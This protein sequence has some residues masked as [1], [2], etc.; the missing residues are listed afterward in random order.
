MENKQSYESSRMKQVTLRGT[1]ITTS[2][3]GFGCAGLMRLPTEAERQRV[4]ATAFD[5]GVRHFD[6]ARMYGLGKVEG[7]LGDFTRTRR[8]QLTITTKFGIQLNAYASR[9]SNIQSAVRRILALSPALR[10]F[11]RR[12]SQALYKEQAFGIEDARQSLETSLRELKTDYIDV[13]LLHECS[14]EGLRGDDLLG[15]LE[16]AHSSGK[17]RCYGIATTFP[18]TLDICREFPNYAPVVQ[19]D[20]DAL[21]RHL[22]VL[23][24]A[25]TRGI[26]THS[27]LSQSL[28]AV[29]QSVSSDTR[30]AAR[31]SEATGLDCSSRAIL[32]SLLLAYCLR[33]NPDG[34]VLF[35]SNTAAHITAN[36]QAAGDAGPSEEAV[37]IFAGLL[38]A[39]HLGA[40][41]ATA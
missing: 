25:E 27:A 19:F 1:P 40:L 28:D 33:A 15:F 17:I 18:N 4:L 34:V 10:Q 26:L 9:F 7:I 23:P 35:H 36:A 20:N 8:D 31:W 37:R 39:G 22:D 30:Q 13:F 6:A 24:G 14:A 11:A 16:D 21:S 32:S 38:A 5:Q 3:L 41:P 29:F 12:R 2:Q